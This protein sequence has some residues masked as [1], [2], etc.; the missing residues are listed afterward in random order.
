MD[1]RL[2]IKKELNAPTQMVWEALTMREH[3]SKWYFSFENDWKL[4]VGNVFEWYA[5]D[6]DCVQWL[7]KGE[8]LEVVS[9]VKLSHTWYYPGYSGMSVVTWELKPLSD[10]STELTLTHDFI[11]PFDETVPALKLENFQNGWYQI[12][13]T[14]LPDYLKAILA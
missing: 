12:I 7:H 6:N 2:I 9:N 5:E 3:T 13:L 1:N 4:E 10:K 8:I 11:E 14:L